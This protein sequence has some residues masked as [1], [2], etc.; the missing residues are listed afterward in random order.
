[1]LKMVRVLRLSRMITYLNETDDV[2]LSL[3]LFKVFFFL[4]LYINITGCFWFYCCKY[5]RRNGLTEIIWNPA[6]YKH[7]EIDALIYNMDFWE[8]Y[9]VSFYNAVLGLMGNDIYPV[10]PLLFPVASFMLIAGALVNANIFGTIA[11]IAQTMN[12]KSQKF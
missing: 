8:Q 5:T 4:I 6:Q 2:K 11:V 7:Y 1:M 10:G 12:I 9:S 3:R